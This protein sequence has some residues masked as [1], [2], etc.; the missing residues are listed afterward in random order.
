MKAVSVES[1]NEYGKPIQATGSGKAP[2]DS[3]DDSGFPPAVNGDDAR[4]KM[5]NA[6]MARQVAQNSGISTETAEKMA[7]RRQ[8][9]E[10]IGQIR[11]LCAKLGE[12]PQFGMNASTLPTLLKYKQHLQSKVAARAKAN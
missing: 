10:L 12:E 1:D 3:E 5:A 7:E 4:H 2:I 11:E 8:K 6:A 9:D